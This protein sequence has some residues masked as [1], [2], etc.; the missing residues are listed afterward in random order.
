MFP[1]HVVYPR[2]R[3]TFLRRIWNRW[4][5]LPVSVRMLVHVQLLDLPLLG[6]QLLRW[7]IRRRLYMVFFALL[8]KTKKVRR[9]GGGRVRTPARPRRRLMVPM[10]WCS[11]GCSFGRATTRSSAVVMCG[12]CGWILPRRSTSS[13]GRTRV[14]VSGSLLGCPSPGRGSPTSLPCCLELLWLLR[15]WCAC[16]VFSSALGRTSL[17]PSCARCV[18]WT[19]STCTSYLAGCRWFVSGFTQYGVVCTVVASVALPALGTFL[20]VLSALLVRLYASEYYAELRS[21]HSHVRC[22]SRGSVVCF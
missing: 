16:P 17:F 2:H 11:H 21:V 7:K 15:C 18:F 12:V 19:F 3:L 1:Y 9:L 14:G 8:H 4:W 10:T 5:M 20:S 22:C 6:L 13:S